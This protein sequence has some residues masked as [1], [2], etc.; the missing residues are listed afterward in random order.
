LDPEVFLDRKITT[1]AAYA[2]GVGAFDAG[3][4]MRVL[5]AQAAH[6]PCL[7]RHFILFAGL[8]FGVAVAAG[9]HRWTFL[10]HQ[11]ARRW[12]KKTI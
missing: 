2:I 9:V 11:C 3:V 12:A 4:L 1:V 5:A 10:C 6:T 8:R 7:H